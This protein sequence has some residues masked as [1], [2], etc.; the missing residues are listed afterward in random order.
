MLP[1]LELLSGPHSPL[2]PCASKKWAGPRSQLGT[3][4]R[5]PSIHGRL[6]LLTE[7]VSGLFASANDTTCAPTYRPTDPR[8]A[9]R[10][11]PNTSYA[12]PIRG[13][14]SCQHGTH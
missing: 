13:S 1:K 10:P 12:A 6:A 9:V 8:I 3:K 2:V 11:L 14:M 7:V 4:S 5:F